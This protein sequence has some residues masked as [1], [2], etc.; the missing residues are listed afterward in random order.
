MGVRGCFPEPSDF[1]RVTSAST[2]GEVAIVRWAGEGCAV[3]S[4]FCG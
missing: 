3:S 1:V 4:L 2:E